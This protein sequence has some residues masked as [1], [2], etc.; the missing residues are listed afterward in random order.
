MPLKLGCTTE[1][2]RKLA[3]IS[4]INRETIKENDA[5]FLKKRA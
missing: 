3:K 5:N 2:T 1:M 4:V